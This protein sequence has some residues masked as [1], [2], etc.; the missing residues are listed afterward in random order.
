ME[1][2]ITEELDKQQLTMISTMYDLMQYGLEFPE[3][4]ECIEKII[5]EL[6]SYYDLDGDFD[7][8]AEFL[9]ML[10]DSK[11]KAI[12]SANIDQKINVV[13]GL[14]QY[15]ADMVMAQGKE[16]TDRINNVQNSMKMIGGKWDLN[17]GSIDIICKVIDFNLEGDNGNQ[18]FLFDQVEGMKYGFE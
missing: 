14:Y 17:Q 8:D 11:D 15:M 9:Q 18:D 5:H 6:D 2:L 16:Y 4:A 1:S 7:H 10:E 3:D 13:L 12:E